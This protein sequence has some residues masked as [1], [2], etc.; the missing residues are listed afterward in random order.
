M[1][2]GWTEEQ[3]ALKKELRQFVAENIPEEIRGRGEGI[4]ATRETEGDDAESRNAADARRA[5]MRKIADKGWKAISWP[6]EYGG[7]DGDRMDQYITEEEMKLCEMLI[8]LALLFS[9]VRISE[10]SAQLINL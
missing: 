9:K 4:E 5:V 6:K 2:F 8:S 1:E 10:E 7:Q 3:L